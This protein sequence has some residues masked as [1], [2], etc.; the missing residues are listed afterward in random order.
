MSRFSV[1]SSDVCIWIWRRADR[2]ME[3]IDEYTGWSVRDVTKRNENTTK[4][5]PLYYQL[6]V[7]TRVG[8]TPLSCPNTLTLMTGHGGRGTVHT[9]RRSC[10]TWRTA[11]SEWHVQRPRWSVGGKLH[12]VVFVRT[13]VT[14]RTPT[15]KSLETSSPGN[16][17]AMGW[18]QH[19]RT[20]DFCYVSSK[21]SRDFRGPWIMTCRMS[22]SLFLSR[23]L[24]PVW[25]TI[26][27]FSRNM[28]YHFTMSRCEGMWWQ[29]YW[30]RKAR[31]VLVTLKNCAYHTATR[32]NRL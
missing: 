19:G 29:L 12:S 5:N 6:M 32:L 15:R 27:P 9:A 20:S 26:R 17:R 24:P 14:W 13:Q 18:A 11:F 8:G 25:D 3:A 28:L 21:N 22:S 16:S 2:E 31:W 1:C 4:K 10:N 7:R 30:R 23:I